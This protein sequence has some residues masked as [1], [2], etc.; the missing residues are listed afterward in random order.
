[1]LRGGAALFSVN[2]EASRV[3]WRH[4]VSALQFEEN[5]PG[6]QDV[7]FS[8]WLNATGKNANIREVRSEG[9]PE[10]DIRPEGIREA[11][12]SVIYLEPFDWR[13]HR[14]FGYDMYSEPVRR[15]AMDKAQDENS[16]TIAAKIILVQE[17]DTLSPQ[18]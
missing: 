4:F 2:E 3:D 17:T 12:T 18:A 6:I 10:Y 15:A 16:A 9:F 7:G 5:H 1:L 11:Y 8:K 14:A 13:I